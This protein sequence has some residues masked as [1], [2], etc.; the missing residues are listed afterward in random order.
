MII[1]CLDYLT[2]YT[3]LGRPVCPGST[4]PA[5]IFVTT[6]TTTFIVFGDFFP[7]SGTNCQLNPYVYMNG[8]NLTLVGFQ[9][10]CNDLQLGR[11]KF[12]GLSHHFVIVAG[13]ES[14]CNYDEF[15]T[16][17]NPSVL[18]ESFVNN[19][20]AVY[21]LND[22]ISIPNVDGSIML[23]SFAQDSNKFSVI[24]NLAEISLLGDSLV[25]SLRIDN[26]LLSF[27]G[28]ISL[29]DMYY[30][31]IQAT[32]SID[33]SFD[34][35]SINLTGVVGS[36]LVTVFQNT[37]NDYLKVLVQ[38]ADDRIMASTTGSQRANN[39]LN[40]SRA[41]VNYQNEMLTIATMEYQQAIQQLEVANQTYI[42]ALQNV[43]EEML[44]MFNSVCEINSCNVV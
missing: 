30:S 7:S 22:F 44:S 16:I 26:T 41:D 13:I 38:S 9:S 23:T 40:A 19:R 17:T 31:A 4:D 3:G 12:T 14:N 25:T 34:S 6:N 29:Y 8:N 28:D 37:I 21:Q 11:L 39:Q 10:N 18:V 1:C 33:Q 32:A 15:P 27:S 42:D 36:E 2:L 5:G 20:N 43:N 24:T 35:L